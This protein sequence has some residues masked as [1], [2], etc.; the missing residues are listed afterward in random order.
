MWTGHVAVE[1]TILNLGYIK[2]WI[3]LPAEDRIVHQVVLCSVD[4]VSLRNTIT[5]LW[6]LNEVSWRGAM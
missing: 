3:C 4:L 6:L 2:F 1:K 5:S